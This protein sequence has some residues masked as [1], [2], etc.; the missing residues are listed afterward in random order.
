MKTKYFRKRKFYRPAF[1]MIELM[2][3]LAVTAL[4][5]LA[6]AVAFQASV[7]N[8][9]VNDD[10]FKAVNKARQ[11]LTIITPQLRTAQAVDGAA[12]ANECAFISASGEDITYRY[13]IAGQKLYM[14]KDSNSYLLCDDVTAMTFTKNNDPTGMY[15]KSVIMSITVSSGSAEQSFSTAVV[16]RKNME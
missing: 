8:Y 6:V 2:I 3:A 11:V 4:I 13:D 14:D 1:S 7:K 10:I 16:I 5:V 12:P 15:V 9:D